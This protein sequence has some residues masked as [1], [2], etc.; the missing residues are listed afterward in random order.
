[1]A[2]AKHE[3]HEREGEIFSLR[4]EPGLQRLRQWLFD[5]QQILNARWPDAAG[6]E[7]TR[8]QGEAKMIQKQLKLLDKGPTIKPEAIK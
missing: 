2:I 4:H 6:E 7:L 3:Q 5:Q 1:M 8:L